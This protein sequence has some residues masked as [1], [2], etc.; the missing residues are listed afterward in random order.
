MIWKRSRSGTSRCSTIASCTASAIAASSSPD[1]P[2]R[3]SICTSGKSGLLPYLD[4][5]V[6]ARQRRGG[7]PVPLPEQLHQRRDQ[8]RA[9]DRRVDQDGERGAEA[10]LLDE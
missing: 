10:E 5:R 3:R 6:Q 4:P 7:P 9:D 1:R 8:Q 2:S